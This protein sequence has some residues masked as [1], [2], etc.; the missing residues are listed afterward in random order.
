MT[1]PPGQQHP[2]RSRS[3]LFTA[4]VAFIIVCCAIGGHLWRQSRLEA[5][6]P[7]FEKQYASEIAALT[8]VG[9]LCF[10]DP[11]PWL[12]IDDAILRVRPLFD[13]ERIL[14]SVVRLPE[15]VRGVTNV[16]NHTR[17]TYVMQK[18]STDRFPVRLSEGKVLVD[19]TWVK[20]LT[21]SK[22]LKSPSGKRVVIE[23]TVRR[24][25]MAD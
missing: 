7:V 3:C 1:S 22:L 16:P 19:G 12:K 10:P 21:Y 9:E 15:M 6:L 2:V 24:D 13:E 14:R 5:S 4:L 18:E 8:E 23:L 11:P 25:A 17:T 20:V